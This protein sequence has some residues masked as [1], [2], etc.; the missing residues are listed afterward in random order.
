M[1]YYFSKKHFSK[2]IFK[3]IELTEHNIGSKVTLFNLTYFTQLIILFIKM[4]FRSLFRQ[5]NGTQGPHTTFN[6]ALKPD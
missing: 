1:A 2:G 6:R 4:F 3:K 5:Q